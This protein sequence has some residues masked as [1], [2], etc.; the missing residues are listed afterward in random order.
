MQESTITLPKLG[1]NLTEWTD[2]DGI[3]EI[4]ATNGFNVAVAEVEPNNTCE[5]VGK[6]VVISLLALSET[7]SYDVSTGIWTAG[8]TTYSFTSDTD[9]LT[10]VTGEIPY[11][12]ASVPL[13]LDAGNRIQFRIVNSNIASVNDLPDGNICTVT[14]A[15]T[16]NNYTKS[17]FETD[18]SLIC[19]INTPN[20]TNITVDIKWGVNV[21]RYT[22]DITSA[23]FEAQE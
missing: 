3:S 4:S 22:Y 19:I 6:T 14:G 18:G 2:W 12:E 1:D 5:K 10:K 23:T 13:G 9:N 20:K 15:T 8:N 11:E 16:S 7:G 17:A 21:V